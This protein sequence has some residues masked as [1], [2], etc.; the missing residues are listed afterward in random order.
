MNH[1]QSPTLELNSG[2][3]QWGGGC[4]VAEKDDHVLVAGVI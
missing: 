3:L 2:H 1:E 4:V